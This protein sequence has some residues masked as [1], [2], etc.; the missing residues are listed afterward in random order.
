MNSQNIR[1][2]KLD[3]IFNPKSIAIVGASETPF[4]YGRQYMDFVYGSG[5]SG[6]IYP[7]TPKHDKIMGIKAYP[8]LAKVSGNI[9]YV[10][11]CVNAS[12]IKEILKQCAMKKVK[13]LH[14]FT[15]RLSETGNEKMKKL[16]QEIAVEAKKIDVRLIGPNCMGLYNPEINLLFNYDLPHETGK[17]GAILQSGGLSGELVRLAAL[18]GMYFSKAISY[19]NAIDINECDL[20]EFFLWDNRT[21]IVLV[22]IEGVKEGQRFAKV[23]SN[24]ASKKPVIVLKAGRSNAGR[25]AVAS[26]T[27]SIAG[28]TNLWKV[29]FKQS[30]AIEVSG[31]GELIDQTLPFYYLPESC[32]KQ[33]GIIGGGGGKSVLAADACEEEGLKIIEMPAGVNSFIE[34][35]SPHLANWLNNPVDMS[36]M[37]GSNIV[38]SE[39]LE[40]MYDDPNFDLL[41]GNITVDAPIDKELWV[42]Y[43][44]M[45]IDA[46]INIFKK[47]KK[48]LVVIMSN[49]ELGYDKVSNWRWETL[50]KQRERL[51]KAGVPVYDS[52]RKAAKALNN[53]VDH[54][55]SK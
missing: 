49:P 13:L 38:L 27:A 26:H 19:G 23:L 28:A 21:E 1:P 32:G 55:R 50:L 41:I 45:E 16:E 11:S 36:I 31:L 40:I 48:P 12:L 44:T 22:Y 10:I 42:P 35:K 2:E 20:L 25:R 14:L 47:G 5:F 3:E 30:K 17:I 53:M 37:P 34:E 29:L 54:C 24:V 43:I 51:V 9:D 18:K 39:L 15:G 33:V 52:V 7:I 46:Y 6:E 8:D 4:S